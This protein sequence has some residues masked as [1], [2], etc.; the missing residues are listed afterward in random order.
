MSSNSNN[1]TIDSNTSTSPNPSKSLSG[2]LEKLVYIMKDDSLSSLI[3]WSKKGDYFRV[4]NPNDFAKTV[5]PKHYK[6]NNWQSFVRQ[7]N[8]YGFHKVNDVFYS[9]TN[10][11]HH[12]DFKHPSFQ[13]DHP[14]LLVNIKRRP[15]KANDTGSKR[16]P[17]PSSPQAEDKQQVLETE[18][19]SLQSKV[20]NLETEL[21]EMKSMYAKLLEQNRILQEQ[22]SQQFQLI[23]KISRT[24]ELDSNRGDFPLKKVKTEYHQTITTSEEDKNLKS[25]TPSLMSSPG[26]QTHMTNLLPPIRSFHLPS[27]NSA[28]LPSFKEAFCDQ[29]HHHSNDTLASCNT[30]YSTNTSSATYLRH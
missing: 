4:H 13:R 23:Q 11:V 7:L 10:A 9:P 3:S 30:R 17:A 28:K 16:S 6:H 18:N 22:Q 14:E 21:S 8:M 1:T 5:L 27:T 25:S 20:Q 12:W 19:T 2:F 24:L 26:P 29:A 15:A